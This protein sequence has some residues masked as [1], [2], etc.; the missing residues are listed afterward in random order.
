MTS[1]ESVEL[2]CRLCGKASQLCR[3]HIIPEFLYRSLY[4]NKHRFTILS[5][6]GLD[7]YAQ[8]GLNE[9][10]LCRSCETRFAGYER[11]AADVM[12]GRIGHHYQRFGERIKIEGIEYNR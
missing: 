6:D 12:R 4:D 7:R 10:L 9:P 11:Y 2:P 1:C 8:R 3:S 5:A